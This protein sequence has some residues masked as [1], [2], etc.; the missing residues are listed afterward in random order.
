MSGEMITDGRCYVIAEIGINHNGDLSKALEMV[1]AAKVADCDAVK[2]QKRTLDVVYTAEELAKP[3][4]NVFGPTNGDLKRG[5]EFSE[6]DYTAIDSFCREV[7]IDWFASPWDQAS[8]EFLMKYD[9]PY[10][11][12]ASAMLTD[13]AFLEHC[14]AT[15]RPLLVS[16]GMADMDLISRAVGV[17]E[18]TGGTIACL[19]HCTSTYPSRDADL[20]LRGIATLKSR[21][22]NLKIGYSGHEEGIL[23]SVLAAALGAVSVERHITLSREDWGSDQKASL[24]MG[25]VAEMVAQIRRA[26]VVLGNGDIRFLEDEKPIAEKLR[27]NHT[28]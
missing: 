1:R 24:E 16:T 2:F 9:S 5:L 3:R 13:K 8:T 19:Y 28:L 15:G 21:F 6:Q 17:I 12:V 14:A 7:G 23:P 10:L 4:D 11:K 27:R 26:E 20:N 18:G 22:P 25:D